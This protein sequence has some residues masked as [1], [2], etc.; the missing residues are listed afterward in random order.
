MQFIAEYIIQGFA[1][2]IGLDIRMIWSKRNSWER[3]IRFDEEGTSCFM[4]LFI[5]DCRS[6]IA[7]PVADWMA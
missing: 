3:V 6:W 4:D 5:I 2:D 1:G 7:F